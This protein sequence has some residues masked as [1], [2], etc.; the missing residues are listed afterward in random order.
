MLAPAD[1][2]AIAA[3]RQA[4]A[5][6]RHR[7][8]TFDDWIAVAKAVAVGRSHCLRVAQTDR[9]VGTKYNR[10]MG[11]WL[12]ANGLAGITAQERHRALQCLDSLP[13]IQAWRA[14]LPDEAC[15]KL[16]HP[17]RVLR[18]FR[19]AA[20]PFCEDPSC[21]HAP[22]REHSIFPPRCKEGA[23]RRIIR[24]LEVY[25]PDPHRLAEAAL[26]G[27]LPHPADIEE[28]L[29]FQAPR[30]RGQPSKENKPRTPAMV[31]LDASPPRAHKHAAA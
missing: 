16:N 22:T 13:A 31:V 26:A 3:G 4:W 15:R 10:Q 9:P 23:R 17:A 11:A 24:T 14:S 28:L 20:K 2:A 5:R 1:D 30:P 8:A 27:A 29:A 6:L 12:T 19:T 7:S 18:H 21:R 25:G